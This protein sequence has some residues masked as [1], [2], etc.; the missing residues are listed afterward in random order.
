MRMPHAKFSELADIVSESIRKQNTTMRMAIPP[1][2]RLVLTLVFLVSG[3]SFQSL[4]FQFRIGETIGEA[5]CGSLK[6]EFLPIS[7]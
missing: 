3:E 7:I 4:S 2:E 6:E 5:I 1:R